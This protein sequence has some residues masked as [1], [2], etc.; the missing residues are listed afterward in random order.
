MLLFA[1]GLDPFLTQ[2]EVNLSG[3]ELYRELEP[4]GQ[5]KARMSKSIRK[6]RSEVDEEARREDTTDY[7]S[8]SNCSGYDSASAEGDSDTA[9]EDG[10][11]G[12][13][14]ALRGGPR[15]HVRP[16]DTE[17]ET[18]DEE[19]GGGRQEAPR[20]GHPNHTQS[21]EGDKRVKEGGTPR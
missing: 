16:E 19:E 13:R 20:G 21:E 8:E 5:Y 4:L 3:V 17:D 15:E 11:G 10:G 9:G 6:T 12:G 1:F 14:G 2:L 7:D 18:E